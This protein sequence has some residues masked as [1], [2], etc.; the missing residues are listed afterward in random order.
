MI[1]CEDSG[2]TP[3]EVIC[4]DVEAC[5]IQLMMIYCQRTEFTLEEWN[6]LPNYWFPY[7]PYLVNENH[8]TVIWEWE[9]TDELYR[10]ICDYQDEWEEHRDEGR[11]LE[12]L[13]QKMTYVCFDKLREMLDDASL[14]SPCVSV[15]K[16]DGASS[17]R[18]IVRDSAGNGDIQKYIA[19]II[20]NKVWAYLDDGR[21]IG[22]SRDRMNMVCVGHGD[23]WEK[24]K[25][26][27]NEPD[28][29]THEELLEA[30]G[31]HEDIRDSI[32]KY[33]EKVFWPKDKFCKHCGKRIVSLYYK[34]PEW[35]WEEMC[36]RAGF[37]YICPYC[38]EYDHFDCEIMN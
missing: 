7:D 5:L 17:L 21:L 38:K 34:S 2:G 26:K 27:L 8:P 31:S 37:L 33:P 29:M 9:A 23:S 10:W 11:Y 35:T 14:A 20:N 12:H 4:A 22:E 3:F 18:L 28:P 15:E 36:G 24:I 30:F 1:C 19:F 32:A 16:T 13:C 6:R 25:A